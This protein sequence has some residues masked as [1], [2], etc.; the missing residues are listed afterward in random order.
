[1]AGKVRLEGALTVDRADITADPPVPSGVVPLDV[2]EVNKP[3]GEAETRSPGLQGPDISLDV[4]LRANRGLFIRGNGLDAEL[5]LDA[6]VGGTV[7]APDL[8]GVAR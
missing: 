7:A 5:S 6:H 8:T 3:G 2:I 4:R 1:A